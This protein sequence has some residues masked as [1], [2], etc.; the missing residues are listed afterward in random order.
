MKS[1]QDAKIVP[2]IPPGA[3]VDNAAFTTTTIDTI[4]FAEADVY[5]QFGALDI[6][7]TALKLQESDASGSGFVDIAAS[8]YTGAFPTATDDNKFIAFHVPL[9]G[10]RKRYLKLV[11]TG[12]DGATGT[13]ATA[14]A[15]LTRGSEHAYTAATRGLLAEK[16]IA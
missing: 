14:F 11:L 6:A 5:V 4:G 15:I 2:V 16:F 13:Y 1:L 3:I 9:L 12:G 10:G 7:P 8:D